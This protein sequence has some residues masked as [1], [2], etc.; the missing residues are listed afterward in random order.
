[1]REGYLGRRP[2]ARHTKVT[3]SAI[4]DA[5]DPRLWLLQDQSYLT[6]MI[7]SQDISTS[8][9]TN[10][11]MAVA[12]SY[13]KVVAFEESTVQY[14]LPTFKNSCAVYRR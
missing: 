1:M 12:K 13:S 6:L 7:I 5:T 14:V 10:S 3:R 4:T 11:N 9:H 8:R 2:N